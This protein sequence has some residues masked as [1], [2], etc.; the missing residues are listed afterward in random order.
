MVDWLVLCVQALW[1]AYN[2][3]DGSVYTGQY[4][5]VMTFTYHVKYGGGGGWTPYIELS[6]ADNL[7]P[8]EIQWWV[9]TYPAYVTFLTYTYTACRVSR[10]KSQCSTGITKHVRRRRMVVVEEE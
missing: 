10:Y 1:Q 6:Y 8:D 2:P 5:S 7:L 3:Q 4:G 9:H